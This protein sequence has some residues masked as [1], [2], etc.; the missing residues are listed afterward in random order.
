MGVEEG[1]KKAHPTL[2]DFQLSRGTRRSTLAS[3]RFRGSPWATPLTESS[4]IGPTLGVQSP[5][6]QGCSAI[7]DCPTITAVIDS[8]R[9]I[10]RHGNVTPSS[11]GEI[12]R[13]KRGHDD[14]RRR[15]P[16]THC[17]LRDQIQSTPAALVGPHQARGN[18]QNAIYD[19]AAS[20]YPVLRPV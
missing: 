5:V 18:F 14:T 10:H 4:P 17:H 11:N 3:H 6:M 1:T 8:T 9:H 15:K 13:P 16:T 19:I 20:G 7:G 12:E 2:R